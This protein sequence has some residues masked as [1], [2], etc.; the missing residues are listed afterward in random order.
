MAHLSLSQSF[1]VHVPK[2]AV[3]LQPASAL[4]PPP[5]HLASLQLAIIL[6]LNVGRMVWNMGNWAFSLK[7]R[8][9]ETYR[10]QPGSMPGEQYR[11][12]VT[13]TTAEHMILADLPFFGNAL[14]RTS[15]R[16]RVAFAG[17]GTSPTGVSPCP[18]TASLIQLL[19]SLEGSPP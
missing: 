6:A 8:K 3:S 10:K 14:V 9:S 5:Q 17:H 19:H 4:S 11:Y 16:S 13:A 15:D 1:L 2:L 7:F 18:L 12:L